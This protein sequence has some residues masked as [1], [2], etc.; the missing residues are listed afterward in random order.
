M[1]FLLAFG[2]CGVWLTGGNKV[3]PPRESVLLADE[4]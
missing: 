2:K 1:A 3:G 4:A